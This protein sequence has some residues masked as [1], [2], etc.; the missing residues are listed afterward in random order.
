MTM[1][2]L[3][4]SNARTDSSQLDT[5]QLPPIGHVDMAKPVWWMLSLCAVSVSN[6]SSR[7]AAIYLRPFSEKDNSEWSG[8]F[9][10]HLSNR[11]NWP[12]LTLSIFLLQTQGAKESNKSV[13]HT[14]TNWILLEVRDCSVLWETLH[15]I[16]F[17]LHCS[18]SCSQYHFLFY[19]VFSSSLFLV[20]IYLSRYLFV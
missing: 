17:S 10:E 18:C 20:H 12:A 2:V 6:M 7:N 1:N 19:S 5:N 13:H 4:R 14:I 15:L 16:S 8:R 9:E 3:F 11:Y